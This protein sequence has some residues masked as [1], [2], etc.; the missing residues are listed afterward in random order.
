[1]EHNSGWQLHR[2]VGRAESR[3]HGLLLILKTS[4]SSLASRSV[5]WV[6][7]LTGS[8]AYLLDLTDDVCPQS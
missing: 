4:L 3:L 5:G 8:P 7:G 6:G 1:M 2:W